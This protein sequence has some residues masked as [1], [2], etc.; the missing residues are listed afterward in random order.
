M[1]IWWE[2]DDGGY[3]KNNKLLIM[4]GLFGFVVLFG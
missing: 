3:K 2:G 1:E 4:M